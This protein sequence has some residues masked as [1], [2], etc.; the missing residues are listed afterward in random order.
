MGLGPALPIVVGGGISAANPFAIGRIPVIVATQPPTETNS[1]LVQGNDGFSDT[2]AFVSGGFITDNGAFDGIG[3]RS[4]AGG[5]GTYLED[6][7]GTG[8]YIQDEADNSSGIYI[9]SGD[10]HPAFAG[11]V[12]IDQAG[13]DS[14][15]IQLTERSTS[16][17]AEIL[18]ETTNA[19][20]HLHP[21]GAGKRVTI[22]ANEG[23]LIAGTAV[24]DGTGAA[25]GTLTNAPA[26]GP[27][28]VWVPID[29]NGVT[30]YF[31]G[32]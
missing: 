25:L 20:I 31:P 26:A 2:I 24:G 21:R 28:T 7:S 9:L 10:T 27:P 29:I 13:L 6:Y 17:N 32:W 23:V 5:G 19:D 15:G 1:V 4:L 12:F 3:F 18:I 14:V 16:G 30:K 22:Q 11:G 8:I